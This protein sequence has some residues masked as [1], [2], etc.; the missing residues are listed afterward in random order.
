M[1]ASQ[2]RTWAIA[3]STGMITLAKWPSVRYVNYFELFRFDS[4]LQASCLPLAMKFTLVCCL[5]VESWWI[6]SN[7]RVI[8]TWKPSILTEAPLIPS[9]N[10]LSHQHCYHYFRLAISLWQRAQET[11]SASQ[12]LSAGCTGWQRAGLWTCPAWPG[13]SH[14]PPTPGSRSTPWRA[15]RSRSPPRRP[16]S[17]VTPSSASWGPTPGTAAAT[18]AGS[19]TRSASTSTLVN[20]RNVQNNSTLILTHVLLFFIK[21]PAVVKLNF[22]AAL[23][24]P[25][26]F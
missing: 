13:A 5:L 21:D 22:R 9:D 11:V 1:L 2:M 20:H 8:I 25:F 17:P 12:T 3:A 15:P 26:W 16:C 10:F 24:W 6:V 23:S 14:S 7:F 4:S 18:S 19:T